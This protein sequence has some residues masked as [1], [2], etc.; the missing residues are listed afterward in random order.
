MAEQGG[1]SSYKDECEISEVVS[2]IRQG[3]SVPFPRRQLRFA[4]DVPALVSS[5]SDIALVLHE[6]KIGNPFAFLNGAT[7]GYFSFI[8]NV[9]LNHCPACNK[10]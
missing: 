9:Y 4:W 10:M 1:P 7:Y 5:R 3:C 6:T 2:L 8:Y